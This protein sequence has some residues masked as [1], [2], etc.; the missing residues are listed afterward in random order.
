MNHNVR[1]AIAGAGVMAMTS[2][3]PLTVAA[4]EFKTR[5][6]RLT[7]N[8]PTVILKNWTCWF[9]SDAGCKYAPCHMTTLQKPA[10]GTLKPSVEPGTIP[11]SGGRCAGK[12]A[13]VLTITYTPRH[14]AHGAEEIVLRS[15]S[16]N[17]ARHILNFHIDVP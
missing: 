17:G 15:I 7:A 14:G 3:V 5:S 16:D 2:L 8:G 1:L 4:E 9:G 11:A 6:Y 12:P 13:P 10:L